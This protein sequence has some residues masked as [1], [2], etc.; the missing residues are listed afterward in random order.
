V[1]SGCGNGGPRTIELPFFLLFSLSSFSS[2]FQ[3]TSLRIC[4]RNQKS[5][6]YFFADPWTR[7]KPEIATFDGSEWFIIADFHQ[8]RT[9]TS[10]EGRFNVL[11]RKQVSGA[12]HV[13]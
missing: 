7:L 3:Q 10:H 9:L 6:R 13:D 5:V 1:A 4:E 12:I 8:A 2:T 11:V